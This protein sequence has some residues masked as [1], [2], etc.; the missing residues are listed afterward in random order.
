MRD[1][2]PKLENIGSALGIGSA[3]R[4][5]EARCFRCGYPTPKARRVC[6]MCLIEIEEA[7]RDYDDEVGDNTGG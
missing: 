4:L 7:T 5:G 3:S 6:D 2:P 1:N